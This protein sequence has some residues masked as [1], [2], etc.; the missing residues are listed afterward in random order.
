MSALFE[1]TTSPV[2]ALM[3]AA[4]L[5]GVERD[6]DGAL[7]LYV[8]PRYH[9]LYTVIEAGENADAIE[10]AWNGMRNAHFFVRPA[11]SSEHLFCDKPVSREETTTAQTEQGAA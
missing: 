10:R 2:A 11:P 5:T 7:K 4:L 3:G 1:V 9:W 6:D 8:G